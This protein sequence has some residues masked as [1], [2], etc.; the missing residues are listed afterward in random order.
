[1]SQV[2]RIVWQEGMFL[3]PQHFQQWDRF[4]ARETWF[5]HN[6]LAPFASGVR[7]IA[8][9]WAALE[10]KRLALEG[11]EAVLPDGTVVNAPALDPLPPARQLD[12]LFTPQLSELSIYLALPDRRPGIPVCRL[13]GRKGTVESSH[14]A[15]AVEVE[16]ENSPGKTIDMSAARQNLK[17]MLSGENLDGFITL[18]LGRIKRDSDARIIFDAAYAP[19][20]LSI[21]AA[22]PVP[23][24]LRSILETL[25]AKSSTLSDQNRQRGGGMVE[26]GSG[27]IGNFWLLHTVN[28]YIPLVSH[29]TE[30]TATHPLELYRTLIQLA[31]SLCTF[32]SQLHPRD[33]PSYN[34]D[35]LAGSFSELTRII[36]ELLETVMPSAFTNIPLVQRDESMFIG[37]IKDEAILAGDCH[38]YLSVSGDLSEARVRDEVPSQVIIGSPHN[39]DFL[40]KTATP[41]LALV[42]TPVPP[43]DFPLKAG[44]TYFK[45]ENEGDTW[46]SVRESRSL[47]IYLGGAELRNC[48]YQ[49][50]AMR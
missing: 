29:L 39:V 47:A 43:R 15:E 8:F 24:L 36:L 33:V 6:S 40:V 14:L 10:N 16:D 32:S 41:G 48:Q 12:E 20:S 11:I 13:G 28:S 18:K 31:G 22:G 3:S 37:E 49:L 7:R 44:H 9:D 25:V 21:E 5:R 17:L 26:F 45:L 19:P 1:M 23:E 34:H 38:W 35:D 4:A 30:V 46:E 50:I 2:N 27:N 42:H